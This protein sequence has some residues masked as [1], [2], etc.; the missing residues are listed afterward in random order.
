MAA[1]PQVVFTVF[2]DGTY[3]MEVRGVTGPDCL[4]VTEDLEKLLPEL[5]ERQLKD[6]YFEQ[7]EIER[8]REN[9]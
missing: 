2:G 4:K 7:P 9:A 5:Q 8:Q 6:E 1:K 3:K